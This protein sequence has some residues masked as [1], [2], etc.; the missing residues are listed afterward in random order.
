M[1]ELEQVSGAQSNCLNVVHGW[2]CGEAACVSVQEDNDEEERCEMHACRGRSIWDASTGLGLGGRRP[3]SL[4]RG[5]GGVVTRTAWLEGKAH[6]AVAQRLKAMASTFLCQ[7]AQISMPFPHLPG[8]PPN[9]RRASQ[10]CPPCLAIL[11]LCLI[12]CPAWSVPVHSGLSSGRARSV[13][14]LIARPTC[15]IFHAVR[16]R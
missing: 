14:R 16:C 6:R 9:P 8:T 2:L 3:C 4:A 15:K 1:A 12:L 7:L 5:Q 10:P 11:R 13:T